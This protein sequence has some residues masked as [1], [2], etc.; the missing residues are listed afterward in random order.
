MDDGDC[1]GT[2]HVDLAGPVHQAA[3]YE[4]GAVVQIPVLP[5]WVDARLV[6]H[7]LF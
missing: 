4:G 1:V 6:K 2:S 3:S 5:D 7:L